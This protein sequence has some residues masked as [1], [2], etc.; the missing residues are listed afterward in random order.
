MPSNRRA[1]LFFLA[2]CG[3]L[4]STVAYLA[5]APVTGPPPAAGTRPLLAQAS[6]P[7]QADSAANFVGDDT[8]TA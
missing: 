8:C 3:V 6:S 2:T 4:C 5:A 1:D 7:A